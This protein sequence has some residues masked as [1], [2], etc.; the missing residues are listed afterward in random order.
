MKTITNHIRKLFPLIAGTGFFIALM[1]NPLFSRGQLWPVSFDGAPSLKPAQ[2]EISLFGAGSYYA[3]KM[4]D[5]TYGYTPGIRV[6]IGIVKNFDVKL[7]Y[8][9]G[10][11][12]LGKLE[13]SRENVV[14]IAPKYAFL[15]DVLAIQVPF[16]VIL[17]QPKKHS[18]FQ[19]NPE[20]EVYYLLNPRFIISLHYKKYVEFNV[21]PGM[22]IYIPGHGTDPTYFVGGNL[23]FAFSGNLNRWSVRPEG[24]IHYLIPHEGGKGSIMYGWGLSF[25]YNINLVKSK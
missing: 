17:Y 12:D 5:G 1:I 8:A 4:Y 11:F 3:S 10:F 9:R 20:L 23:G 2:L 13:D 22:Q 16:S 15:S 6:G 18:D 19:E 14:G 21:A 7:S 25:T 24:F